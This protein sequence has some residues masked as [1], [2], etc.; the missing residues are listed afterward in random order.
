MGSI[1]EFTCRSCGYSSG[2]LSV[3]WGRAGRTRYWGGLG[4]CATCKRLCVVDL[5]N[6]Q[7]MHRCEECQGALQLLEGLAADIPCPACN[8]TIL[9]TNNLGVWN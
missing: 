9:R 4:V 2:S 5:A 8:G 3:G 6:K 1:V 7:D